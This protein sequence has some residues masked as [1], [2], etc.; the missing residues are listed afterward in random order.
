M[1]HFSLGRLATLLGRYD[2][3]ENHL[4][5]AHEIHAAMPAPYFLDRT[6]WAWA[7]M[8]LTRGDPADHER[9]RLLATQAHDEAVTRGFGLVETDTT[10]TLA[11]LERP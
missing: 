1:F 9:A 5:R 2:D 7:E 3:A 11:R 6:R 4:G 8:L 10:S